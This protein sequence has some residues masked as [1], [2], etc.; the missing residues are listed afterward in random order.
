MM[1]LSNLH[2]LL[3]KKSTINTPFWKMFYYNAIF[4]MLYRKVIS[5]TAEY[6]LL[7]SI[8]WLL[9]IGTLSTSLVSTILS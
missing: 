8:I 9:G 4:N 6:I 2:M 7:F 1:N 5:D 3:S